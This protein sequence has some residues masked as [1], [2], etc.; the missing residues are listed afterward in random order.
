MLRLTSPQRDFWDDLL[1]PEARIMSR[2]LAAVLSDQLEWASAGRL[3]ADQADQRPLQRAGRTSAR[4]AGEEADREE[5]AAGPEGAGGYHSGGSR[6]SLP[7][8]R[9]LAC[10]WGPG[11]DPH[12]EAAPANGSR[13]RGEVP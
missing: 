3:D 10:R 11:G 12:R 1:P 13:D 8:R 5:G 6:H 4:C 2:Q 9:G 7:D